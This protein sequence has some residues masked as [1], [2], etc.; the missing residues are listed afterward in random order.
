M[1]RKKWFSSHINA[2]AFD[3]KDLKKAD[4]SRE[5]NKEKSAVL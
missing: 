2:T 4:Q 1:Q 5:E 3:Q